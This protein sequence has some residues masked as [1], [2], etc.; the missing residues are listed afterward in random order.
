MAITTEKAGRMKIR[1]A[2]IYRQASLAFCIDI[3]CYNGI[4]FTANKF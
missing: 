4:I 2:F 1:S 3:I